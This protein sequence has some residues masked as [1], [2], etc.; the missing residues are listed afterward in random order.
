MSSKYLSHHRKH[1]N[2]HS[3]GCIMPEK[4]AVPER[5][6]VWSTHG[7]HRLNEHLHFNGRSYLTCMWPIRTELKRH[8]LQDGSFLYELP[9]NDPGLYKDSLFV[10]HNISSKEQLFCLW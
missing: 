5:S 1:H 3:N 9:F 10:T 7:S 4:P 6:E 8:K 2:F